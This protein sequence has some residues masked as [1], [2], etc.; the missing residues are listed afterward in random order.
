M[1]V[2]VQKSVYLTEEG[3]SKANDLMK[4]IYWEGRINAQHRLILKKQI[5]VFASSQNIKRM[6]L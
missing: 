5:R 1:E 6:A 3:I 2:N 4:K